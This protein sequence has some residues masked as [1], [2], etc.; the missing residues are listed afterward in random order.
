MYDLNV[1]MFKENYKLENCIVTYRNHVKSPKDECETYNS[2]KT[3]I[4]D[5]HEMLKFI[6][7]KDKL[8]MFLCPFVLAFFKMIFIVI[9]NFMKT[10]FYKEIYIKTS[11][12]NFVRI[13]IL[14]M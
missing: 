9:H 14:K 10:I 3:H 4:K 6:K 2:L 1:K 5:L 8:D 7:G 12:E 13:V 11:N